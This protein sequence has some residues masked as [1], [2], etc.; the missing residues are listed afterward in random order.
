MVDLVTVPGAPAA[1]AAAALRRL[2]GLRPQAYE[3]PQDRQALDAL[4]RTRGLDTLVRKC[5]EWGFERLLRVQLTGSSLRVTA[6]AF[7]QLQELFADVCATL[8]LPRVPELYVGA[9]GE[10]EALTAGVDHPLVVLSSGAVDQLDDAELR[11]LLARE[12]GHVKSGHVLYYQIAEFLPLISEAIGD[13]T[14][15]VGALLGAGLQLALLN[16]RRKSEHTADRAGLL[17]VQDQQVALSVLMKLS[18][19]PQRLRDAVN[20]DDFVAQARAF[21]AL[22]S[23]KLSWFAK[24]LGASG[25]SHPWTVLRAKECVA[26]VEAGGYERVLA[27]PAEVP[28]QLPPGVARFCVH[29][30]AGLGA[31]AAYCTHCGQPVATTR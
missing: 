13:A 23:D 5:N 21:D 24:W 19:L 31:A 25:R 6:D 22:D 18:G 10:I 20:V 30:G 27:A 7:P 14:F 12:V 9:G 2:P 11:F 29:C 17:A 28:L 15:G 16:W 26:W 4:Q 3:H 8:D 1:P